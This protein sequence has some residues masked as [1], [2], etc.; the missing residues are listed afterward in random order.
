MTV[1]RAAESGGKDDENVIA[2]VVELT[3]IKHAW[4]RNESRF[5]SFGPLGLM[6]KLKLGHLPIWI[7]RV[8]RAARTAPLLNSLSL[9][10]T[11][12]PPQKL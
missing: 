10:V 6:M 8:R 5:T 7:A 3:L 4:K 2:I 1:S 11:H 9:C 12:G